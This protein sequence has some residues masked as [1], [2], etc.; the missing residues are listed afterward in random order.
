[1]FT[2][3]AKKRVS[4][5]QNFI[6]YSERGLEEALHEFVSKTKQGI[7]DWRDLSAKELAA[8]YAKLFVEMPEIKVPSRVR[9][10]FKKRNPFAGAFTRLYADLAAVVFSSLESSEVGRGVA[11]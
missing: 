3:P 7:L 4:P 5:E 11:L 2:V 10:W 1:M 8:F 6:A 9:L